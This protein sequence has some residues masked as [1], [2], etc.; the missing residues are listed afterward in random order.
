MRKAIKIGILAL[1]L[2]LCGCSASHGF[3]W[4]PEQLGGLPA[5]APARPKTPHEYPA[6]HDMPPPRAVKPLSDTDLLKLEKELQAVRAR[7]EKA[8]AKV[9]SGGASSSTGN[10]GKP[11]RP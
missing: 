10:A 3:D 6:V 4:L 1:A 2:G 8:A 7:Q 5:D 9:Q 11:S